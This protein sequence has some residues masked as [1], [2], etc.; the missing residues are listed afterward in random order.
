MC[1][2]IWRP[3]KTRVKDLEMWRNVMRV[4]GGVGYMRLNPRMLA[5]NNLCRIK[6]EIT[7]I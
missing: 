2:H 6:G 3:S 5:V 4:R 1:A 7:R